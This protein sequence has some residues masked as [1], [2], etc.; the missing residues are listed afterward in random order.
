MCMDMCIDMCADNDT[1]TV[2]RHICR[3]AHRHVCGVK[4]TQDTDSKGIEPR[5]PANILVIDTTISVITTDNMSDY[6]PMR[7]MHTVSS[8][9][10][11]SAS[12]LSWRS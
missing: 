9:G 8:P 2:S 3:H 10:I 11:Q 5:Y 6:S 1:D 7:R 12:I 4:F